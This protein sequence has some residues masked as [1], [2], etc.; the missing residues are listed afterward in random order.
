MAKKL[1]RRSFLECAL[2]GGAAAGTANLTIMKDAFAQA[3]GPL[4][5]GHHCDLTGIIS[6]WGLWH[7]RVAKAAVEVV[8]QGGGIAGRKVELAPKIPNPT[9]PAARAAAQCDPAWQCGIRARFGSFGRDAG[10]GADRD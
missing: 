9:R 6:S 1:S 2:A 7:D 10:F 4:V 3:S 5:I 8:N